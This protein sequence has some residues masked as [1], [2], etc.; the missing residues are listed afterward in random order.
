MKGLK[1]KMKRALLVGICVVG[2]SAMTVPAEAGPSDLFEAQYEGRVERDPGTWLGFDVIRRD[3]AR[4]VG[5]I[6]GLLRY[7]CDS[8]EGGVAYARVRGK[9]RVNGEG[10]FS[11]KLEGDQV[12]ARGAGDSVTYDMTG[13]LRDGGGARGTIDSVLRFTSMRR[14]GESVRCYTGELSWRAERGAETDPI[15]AAS[16]WR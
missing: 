6:A 8:G 14:G 10:R 13:R 12:K 5:R 9:L 4:K 15:F 7:N 1:D 3:G 11:G 16:R 2:V